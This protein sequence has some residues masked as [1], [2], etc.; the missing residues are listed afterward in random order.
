M[1]KLVAVCRDD[2]FPFERRQIP[3]M[4]E[5]TLTMVMEIPE[6]VISIESVNSADVINFKKRYTCLS[7]GELHAALLVCQKDLFALLAVLVPCVGCRRSVERLYTQLWESCQPAIEP[8]I[9]TA[10]GVLTVSENFLVDPK[11]IYALFYIHGS[12][13]NDVVDTIPKSKRNRRCILHSLET[14]KARASGSWMDVW[15]LLSQECRDE[16]VLIDSDSLLDTLENYLRKHRFCSECKSKVLRAYSILAGDVDGDAEK[17]YCA[18]LYEGLKSCPKDRHIHVVCDTDFIAHLIGRAEPELAGGRRERHARTIDIA[19]EEVL[20]CLGIH[21]W[22]RL[23]RLWQK[24]RAEEQTWQMLFYLGIEALRKRFETAVEEK[25]GITQLELVVEEIS[26]AERVIEKRKENKR[27]KRKKRKENKRKENESTEIEEVVAEEKEKEIEDDEKSSQLSQED[28]EEEDDKSSSSGT[29]KSHDSSPL[30]FDNDVESSSISSLSSQHSSC[31]VSPSDRNS[32]HDRSESSDF[33]SFHENDNTCKDNDNNNVSEY[34]ELLLKEC[35]CPRQSSKKNHEHQQN[36]AYYKSTSNSNSKAYKYQAG[37]N[38]SPNEH[39]YNS[40]D[41]E[42]DKDNGGGGK[43]GKKNGYNQSQQQY[44]RPAYK[45]NG[46]NNYE[47]GYRNNYSTIA[48]RFKKLNHYNDEN[49]KSSGGVHKGGN[50]G[51]G[52]GGQDVYDQFNS[53]HPSTTN[54]RGRGKRKGN[55]NFKEHS[56]QQQANS[57]KWSTNEYSSSKY[58]NENNSHV[59]NKNNHPTSGGGGHGS[60]KMNGTVT[61]TPTTAVEDEGELRLLKMMGW[62]SDDSHGISE[63]EIKE[64]SASICDVQIQRQELRENIREQFNKL[65]VNGLFC[66]C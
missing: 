13:L 64:F 24:L 45:R 57:Q 4:I 10:A 65:T 39:R 62:K 63:Q 49:W 66:N 50:Q 35:P 43:Y 47:N 11:L 46:Y 40:N 26:E 28:N 5:E 6:T 16:V 38:N 37:R 42:C 1:A 20:T 12:H 31:H 60:I 7:H 14:H 22:E 8:L 25:Q 32:K 53:N 19:Q 29:C 61:P 54:G 2:E 34:N 44:Q 23:H 51:G 9:I 36:S 21:L 15:D 30:K 48:P 56:D 41:C 17:G 33:N 55:K 59:N 27:L 58:N 3:L 18:A 52:G